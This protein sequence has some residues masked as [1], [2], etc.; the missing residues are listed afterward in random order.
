[1][2][3]KKGEPPNVTKQQSQVMLKLHNV[4][5]ELINVR[6]KYS[7]TKCNK[8]TVRCDVGIVKCDKRTVTCDVRIT[9]YE[10]ETIKCEKKNKGTTECDEVQSLVM[11]VMHNVRMDSSNVRKK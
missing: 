4:R 10:D 8:S 6:K 7:T 11:L 9:Q 5:M 3:K 2:R 1:M